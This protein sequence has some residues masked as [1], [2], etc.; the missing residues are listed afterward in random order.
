[1]NTRNGP[2][3]APPATG[4]A[5]TLLAAA[6]VLAA[7]GEPTPPEP[8]NPLPVV[9]SVAP[10]L[11]RLGCPE[12]L[13]VT[14]R[15]FVPGVKA[16]VHGHGEPPHDLDATLVDSTALRVRL[17][18]ALCSAD[19]ELW[20]GARNP[21]PGGGIAEGF[22]R[23]VVSSAVFGV[24]SVSPR[25]WPG[26]TWGRVDIHGSGFLQDG[27]IRFA[28]QGCCTIDVAATAHSRTRMS[29]GV[30]EAVLTQPGHYTVAAW[31]PGTSLTTSAFPFD[32]VSV[33]PSVRVVTPA[34]VAPSDREIV[35]VGH[36]LTNLTE[37]RV[38]DAARERRLASTGGAEQ[39]LYVTLLPGDV[40]ASGTLAVSVINPPV[41]IPG[42]PAEASAGGRAD[43]TVPAGWRA[44]THVEGTLMPL[45]AASP[46]GGA[47]A[48]TRGTRFYVVT[49]DVQPQA[50]EGITT[51]EGT[52]F[53][54]SRGAIT[55]PFDDQPIATLPSGDETYFGGTACGDRYCGRM[56][57]ALHV[58]GPGT[59]TGLPAAGTGSHVPLPAHATA[60]AP[61][62]GLVWTGTTQ[63]TIEVVNTSGTGSVVGSIPVV[64]GA[65]ITN[66]VH[67]STRGV[68]YV[69]AA[70]Q[71]RIW[72]VDLSAREVAGGHD[73]PFVPARLA[74]DHGSGDVVVATAVAVHFLDP[75]TGA[76]AIL[77]GTASGIRDVSV[78]TDGLQ[79][80]VASADARAVQLFTLPARTLART[81]ALEREPRRM[82]YADAGAALIVTSPD[83]TLQVIR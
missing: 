16:V 50:G 52:S 75:D 34:Q 69:I 5:A 1:M 9:A 3:Y 77:G 60:I 66:I 63:G 17:P 8:R 26:G 53:S 43:L 21:E 64:S 15:H 79:L 39:A 72:V 47:V 82:A 45:V 67:D 4:A 80:A 22:G 7:C 81:V 2:G 30:P 41:A 37:V 55:T 24:D 54:Y 13:T 25:L 27:A 48:G 57:P 74:W 49:R 71:A 29:A 35:I 12:P 20:I 70:G 23:V 10:E 68:L 58:M 18:T 31:I 73:L 76:L 46:P 38:G 51:A 44:A 11:M 83:P 59:S 33:P 19:T 56:Y 40:P 14:G 65:A 6:T 78:S 61:V 42:V 32:V 28:P 36:G 62:A